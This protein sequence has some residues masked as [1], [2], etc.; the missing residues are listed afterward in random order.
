MPKEV[1]LK[2]LL[3]PSADSGVKFYR[4]VGKWRN[5]SGAMDTV[6]LRTIRRQGRGKEIK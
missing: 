1:L 6:L 2:V 5:K 4:R 3:K